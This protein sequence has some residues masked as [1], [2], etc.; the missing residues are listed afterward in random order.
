M[1]LYAKACLAL[2]FFL[3]P[4]GLA[5]QVWSEFYRTW[6]GGDV[7]YAYSV[8]QDRDGGFVVAGNLGFVN[9]TLRSEACIHKLDASGAQV[10]TRTYG[11]SN[12]EVG[13]DLILTNDGG[14]FL[15][16][17]TGSF[18]S[19]STD[20]L[21]VKTDGNGAVQWSRV[22]GGSG[23]DVALST[24][25]TA[26]GGY[27]V[28]GY[29]Y[30]FGQ[31]NGDYYAVKLSA[32]GNLEWS[33]VF[34]GTGTDISHNIQQTSD[35]GYIMGGYT[36]SFGSGIGN[37]YLVRL[38]GAGTVVWN[39]VYG[40]SA[41]DLGYRTWQSSDG[42]YI[43]IGY[44][45][46]FGAGGTDAL[47]IKTDATGA[48]QWARTYGGP[49]M[50][51]PYNV[52]EAYDG[53]YVITGETS[54]STFGSGDQQILKVSNT[55]TLIWAYHYGSAIDETGFGLSVETADSGI[56]LSGWDD[57]NEDL[58][59]LK[60]DSLGDPG[61]SRGNTT[62][63]TGVPS[64][65]LTAGGVSSSG[66]NFANISLTANPIVLTEITRCFSVLDAGD[67]ALNGWLR[68]EE[69]W[70]EW[71][72]DESRRG[73]FVLEASADG[74]AFEEVYRCGGTCRTYRNPAGRKTLWYRLQFLDENGGSGY[75]NTVL[76]GEDAAVSRAAL[77]AQGKE[78]YLLT[79]GDA[80]VE[81]WDMQ[82]RML[83]DL[84]MLKEGAFVQLDGLG[85]GMYLLRLR[86]Q[87]GLEV[88]RHF[89]GK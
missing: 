9:S 62:L 87:E 63:S 29:T 85:A 15:V 66:G 28:G 46:T 16:G 36:R 64:L 75:S 35:G 60:T 68:G 51:R 34:G 18:G 79:G 47:L 65:S 52:F 22:M 57:N 72:L 41:T 38:D 45:T 33:R 30:S 80:R 81:I 61:C 88:F 39:R 67:L 27:I 24:F 25:Q 3:L 59:L 50:D 31:G 42:G 17:S 89:V 70:L 71:E 11:G 49:L 40:G 77:V 13:R 74:E 8:R 56:V 1:Y 76:L 82:G 23:A 37:F 86:G 12:A 48:L 73:R 83:R 69:H 14:Y 21:M 32:A 19:G 2:S 54:N 84:G 6:E 7:E 78:S 5:A 43:S 26:D 44:T 55:G 20:F 4:Y 58:L 10:W 53:N